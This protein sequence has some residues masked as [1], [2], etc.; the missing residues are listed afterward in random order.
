MRSVKKLV[1]IGENLWVIGWFV[2]LVEWVWEGVGYLLDER[3]DRQRY[4]KPIRF[5]MVWKKLGRQL[6]LSIREGGEREKSRRGGKRWG[7]VRGVQWVDRGV[8]GPEDRRERWLHSGDTV[9]LED[10]KAEKDNVGFW[11][12]V[13]FGKEHPE[14]MFMEVGVNEDTGSETGA[15]LTE[16]EMAEA[17]RRIQAVGS[18]YQ[19]EYYQ[20]F[21][22]GY[23]RKEDGIEVKEIGD[24]RSETRAG[25]GTYGK[26][27]G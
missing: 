26:R 2:R 9:K 12:A 27:L 16:E 18:R 8:R 7:W 4:G 1:R 14:I 13:D 22:E 6:N 23:G 11:A 17:E 5:W 20:K 25:E 19:E 10:V 24:R 15:G 21:M 3:K